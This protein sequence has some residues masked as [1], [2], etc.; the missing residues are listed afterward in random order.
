MTCPHCVGA[1]A[2]FD[3]KTARKELKRLLKKGPTASTKALLDAVRG[4]GE[5]LL[6]IG[7]GVGAIQHVL[8]EA[9]ARITGVDASRAYLKVA[10]EEAER[11][12]YGERA[13][14]KY[15]DFVEV[16][17][18]I[19]Q[20]DVVTLD[21]VLCCYPDVEALVKASTG[22]A[23]K[24]YA[25][26]FPKERWWTRALIGMLNVGM[27]IWRSDY[28]AYIHPE[29]RVELLVAAAGLTPAHASTTWMWNVRAWTRPEGT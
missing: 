23:R 10:G 3:T 25:V 4:K 24:V 21:R 22:K 7:G 5:S 18:E 29:E 20:H 14:Q 2:L 28:R 6:D 11:R 27:W 12:G 1:D 16:A 9:G 26:V 13:V 8:G 19:E 17:G 15:G